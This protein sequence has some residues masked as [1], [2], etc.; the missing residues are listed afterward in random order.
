MGA[1]IT[2]PVNEL[3]KSIVDCSDGLSYY[4]GSTQIW[5]RAA[6]GTYAREVSSVGGGAVRY[7]CEYNGYI[8]YSTATGLGRWTIGTAWST[9]NDTWAV[10]QT[11]AYHPM[12]V[13]NGILYIGD[14]YF[15][16]QVD[17]TTFTS[18]VFDLD[19][20]Y[21]ITAMHQLADDLIIGTR[22]SNKPRCHVF[23]WDRYSSTWSGIQEIP[24]TG[25]NAFVVTDSAILISAGERGAFY[26][27]ARDRVIGTLVSRFK[28]IPGTFNASNVG[29]VYS[30]ASENFFGLP[31]FGFSGTT[32]TPAKCGI[33][34]I[35]SQDSGFPY[36]LNL[37]FRLSV[38]A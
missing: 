32:G 30:G 37:E 6:N 16:S 17:G 23:V 10:L 11:A 12:V 35:G 26:S 9:R 27:W 22:I 14:G 4:F 1:G 3:V 18:N 5:S 19:T 13:N 21:T 38:S 2:N 20:I 29:I 15:V 28:R 24:E 34:S 31:V 7:A 33:Y 25:I 8:F 36:V